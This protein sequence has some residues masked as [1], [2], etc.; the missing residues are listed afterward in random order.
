MMA[1][2]RGSALV[3]AIIFLVL[4][5]TLAAF[6]A[7]ISSAQQ[8]EAGLDVLGSRALY[9]ARAGAEWGLYRALRAGSCVP[10]GQVAHPWP[11]PIPAAWP[12]FPVEGFT[13][14]VL[15]ESWP[16]ADEG[17]TPVNLLRITATACN[18]PDG[19][20]GRCPNNGPGEGYV[21]RQWTVSGSR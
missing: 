21:E 19:A 2:L 16:P 3:A 8:V 17:G 9:A 18:Q 20:N 15:C 1:R 14:T 4:L 13:V 10:G 6:L 7:R 12:A 11:N 5:A